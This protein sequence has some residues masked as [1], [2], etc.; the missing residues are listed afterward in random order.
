MSRGCTKIG[1]VFG[2]VEVVSSRTISVNGKENSQY[3]I[4]CVHCGAERWSNTTS[5]RR[6]TASCYVCN[7]KKYTS[8]KCGETNNYPKKLYSI[9]RG[10]KRRCY[11]EKCEKYQYY[12]GRGIIIC[13]EWLQSYSAFAEWA[14]SHGWDDTKSIDRIDVDGNYC[15]DNCRWVTQKEQTNNQRKNIHV[16]YMGEKITLAKFCEKTGLQYDRARY[17]I[18]IKHMNVDDVLKE[19][20]T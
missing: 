2:N 5:V 7:P 3:L 4:R 9:Y 16:E 1:K 6:C 18:F 13:D 12:G 11:S 15:P 8:V 10:M 19:L 17:L 20:N 14:L